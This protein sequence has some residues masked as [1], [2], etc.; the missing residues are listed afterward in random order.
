M[1][2]SNNNVYMYVFLQVEQDWGWGKES[3]VYKYPRSKGL[4]AIIANENWTGKPECKREGTDTD[5]KKIQD[6]FGK[7]GYQVLPEMKDL[8]AAEMDEYFKN[9]TKGFDLKMVEVPDV[10]VCF[11]LSHGNQ[12]GIEGVDGEHVQLRDLAKQLESDKCPALKG[13]PKLFFVQACRG[14]GQPD[15]VQ[16]DHTHLPGEDRIVVDGNIS[17]IPPGAD[18]LFGYSTVRDNASLRKTISGSFYIQILCDAIDQYHKKLSLNDIMMYIHQQLATGDQYK[19]EFKGKTYR[20]MAEMVTTL[21][22]NVYFH[23]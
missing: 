16:L 6:T 10:F 2:S 14:Q 9:F 15:Q 1:V 5:V 22:G 17:A 19:Y 11:I 8:K 20:Q 18:F 7:L 3:I 4:V 21:R 23:K 12:D 13:K